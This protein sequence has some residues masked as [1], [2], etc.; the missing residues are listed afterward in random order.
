MKTILLLV[1]CP[2]DCAAAPICNREKDCLPPAM[3]PLSDCDPRIG[4]AVWDAALRRVVLHVRASRARCDAGTICA[5]LRRRS[6]H[7]E[8]M[9]SGAGIE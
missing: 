3:L 1:C 7:A 8:G 4:T 6:L 2:A 9:L 5:V